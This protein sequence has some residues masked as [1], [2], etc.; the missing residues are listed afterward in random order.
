MGHLFIVESNEY[1]YP[2]LA[3]MWR[4]WSDCG[5]IYQAFY[6]EALGII[7]EGRAARLYESEVAEIC[8]EA[9]IAGHSGTIAYMKS[10]QLGLLTQDLQNINPA[11]IL[12]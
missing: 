12:E 6:P 10:Q 3:N 7:M 9:V 11:K 2:Q 8:R 5:H 4:M 1:R